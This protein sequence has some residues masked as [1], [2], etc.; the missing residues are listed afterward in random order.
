V[1]AIEIS[2]ITEVGIAPKLRMVVHPVIRVSC[3]FEHEVEH[4]HGSPDFIEIAPADDLNCIVEG[5]PLLLFCHTL[6]PSAFLHCARHLF[7]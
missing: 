1:R 5:S 3:L 6:S 4:L 7:G 2:G